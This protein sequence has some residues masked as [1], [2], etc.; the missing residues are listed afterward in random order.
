MAEPGRKSR[1]ATRN[2]S[3]ERNGRHAT[4]SYYASAV[5]PSPWTLRGRGAGP[6]LLGAAP[7]DLVEKSLDLLSPL[8]VGGGFA[9]KGVARVAQHLLG[10]L[11]AGAVKGHRT[12]AHR[13]CQGEGCAGPLGLG[14]PCAAALPGP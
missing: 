13:V 4:K 8:V 5:T 1:C 6:R 2:R 12:G 14:A 3:V 11:E 10:T 7:E 9:V